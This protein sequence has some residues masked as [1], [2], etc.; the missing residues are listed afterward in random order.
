MRILKNI[1]KVLFSRSTIAVILL[2]I[3]LWLFYIGYAFFKEYVMFFYGGY[4]ILSIVVVIFIL[5]NQQNPSFKMAWIIP[6]LA[7]PIFGTFMYIWVRLQLIPKKLNERIK[8]LE[9]EY[10]FYLD[11]NNFD[12]KE[13]SQDF[14]NLA[15]YMYQDNYFPAYQNTKMEYFSSGEAFFE[16]VI[17]ELDKAKKFIFLE[18]FI[19]ERGIMWNKILDILKKKVEAGV[20][21]RLL[22]DGTC[23]IVLLPRNYPEELKKLGIKCQEYSPLKPFI[24]TYHNNRD[25]RKILVIDGIVS[26]T[27][28][29]N[30]AD[31]YINEKVRFGYWKDTA[32]KMKG[33][34]TNR[35]TLM[36][37]EMWNISISKKE[38]YSLYLTDSKIK[39][40]GCVIPYGENPFDQE[41]LAKNVFLDTIHQAKKY[42]H[43]MTPYLILDNELLTALKLAARKNVETVIMMPHIPD[44]MYAYWLG[45]T[46][47]EDLIKAGVQIVEFIPGFVHAKVLVSDDEKA[48]VGSC[49]F[50]YRSLYLN[51]EC[52]CYIYRHSVIS[53][54]EDDFQETMKQCKTITLKDCHSLK[55]T[56]KVFGKVLRLI[57]PLM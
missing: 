30:L 4:T 5:N 48:I 34:A 9:G 14:Q 46:Y 50:D 40:K 6:V 13:V 17:Q 12:I 54:I 29:I 3:Q 38:N 37:L 32:I 24:S 55:I 16:D 1:S 22:Y 10:A 52:G 31:E 51:F 42:I 41:T 20:E 2:L 28:G 44:K 39:E 45:R 35:F 43:I 18:F 19:I 23:S 49:N 56:Y 8:K 26:Y 33:D 36:F 27:G 11:P 15:H 21:V 47:Y 25:H 57:A 7:L 53:E